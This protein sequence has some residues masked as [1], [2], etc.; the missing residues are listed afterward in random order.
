MCFIHS[1]LKYYFLCI[2]SAKFVFSVRKINYRKFCLL[3][4]ITTFVLIC[5]SMTQNFMFALSFGKIVVKTVGH[6]KFPCLE[7]L[8]LEYEEIPNKYFLHVTFSNLLSFKKNKKLIVFYRV[9]MIHKV[10]GQMKPCINFCFRKTQHWF[11]TLI[12]IYFFFL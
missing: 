4:I 5:S 2:Y 6:C 10:C 3:F 12:F 9:V 1:V 11:Y 7:K 8:H